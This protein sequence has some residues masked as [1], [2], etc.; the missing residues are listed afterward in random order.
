[1]TKEEALKLIQDHTD[2]GGSVDVDSLARAI[3]AKAMG[4]WDCPNYPCCP[5]ESKSACERN[6][7]APF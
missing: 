4:W 3:A 5:C 6:R 1:M 2:Y 7:N